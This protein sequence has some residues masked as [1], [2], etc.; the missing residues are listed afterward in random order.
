MAPKRKTTGLASFVS[1]LQEDDREASAEIRVPAHILP[2]T[3]DPSYVES[4]PPTKK[5]KRIG[6]LGEGHEQYDATGLAPFYTRMAEVPP[7]L[8]KCMPVS[9]MILSCLD[10]PELFRLCTA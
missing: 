2:L 4:E 5:R 7:P 8:K 9:L 10:I 3:P 6:M 1:F